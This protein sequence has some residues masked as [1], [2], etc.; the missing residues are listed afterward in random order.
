MSDILLPELSQEQLNS[1]SVLG[2]ANIGDAVYE[3]LART[4][5]SLK[6]FTGAL[7]MHRQ[8]INIVNARAQAAAADKIMPYLTDD[9]LTVYKR[10]RNAKVNSVPQNASVGEYHAATGIETL[11]GFLYLSGKSYRCEELFKLI[12]DEN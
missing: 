9:E 1:Y 12:A 11:F 4:H 6:G 2:L 5:V 3:L 10:G 7:D 8:T